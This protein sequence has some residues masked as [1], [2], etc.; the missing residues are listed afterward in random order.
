[1]TFWTIENC[2]IFL[3]YSAMKFDSFQES[4]ISVN[5]FHFCTQVAEHWWR[6][7]ADAGWG[8]RVSLYTYDLKPQMRAQVF[9]VAKPLGDSGKA[10]PLFKMSIS[11][12]LST[13]FTT[14]LD[15]HSQA[16]DLASY[17]KKK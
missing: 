17:F 7:K 5:L 15:P 4:P 1:M 9:L 6:T 11:V 13:S 8:G 2:L 12:S 16:H 14:S 10:L 3:G